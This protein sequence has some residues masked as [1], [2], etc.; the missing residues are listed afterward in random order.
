MN[1]VL[2][3]VQEQVSRVDRSRSLLIGISA[4]LTALWSLYRVFWLFYSMSVLSGVG[5][6]SGSLI[7]STVFWGAI[8]VVAGGVSAVFLIRYLKTT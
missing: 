3:R 6:S 7:F 5:Y 4:G 8:A 1:T 2:T